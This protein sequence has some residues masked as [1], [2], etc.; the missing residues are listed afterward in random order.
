MSIFV[1]FCVCCNSEVSQFGT[2][3]VI[4]NR[5]ESKDTMPP[6]RVKTQNLKFLCA[7]DQQ[8]TATTSPLDDLK[9]KHVK[10]IYKQKIILKNNQIN[11]IY[12]FRKTFSETR[13]ET[14]LS[15]FYN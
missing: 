5:I 14:F 2:N 8:A 1:M 3:K 10:S 7:V 11:F 15:L 6:F 4:S 9:F 13:S 12:V